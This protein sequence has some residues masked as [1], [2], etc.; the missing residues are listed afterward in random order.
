MLVE[1]TADDLQISRL[2]RSDCPIGELKA[3]VYDL[4]NDIDEIVIS[5]S[6]EKKI[7]KVHLEEL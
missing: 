5:K 1:E 4:A 3:T 2:W 7:V 6:H